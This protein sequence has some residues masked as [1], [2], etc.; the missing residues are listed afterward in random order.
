MSNSLAIA[1]AAV[2]LIIVI[3]LPR[4]ETFA[5]TLGLG[6]PP[7]RFDPAYSTSYEHDRCDNNPAC[8]G[9]A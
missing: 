3:A 5:G 4:R 1:V 2:V 8:M 6:W 7:I 9:F